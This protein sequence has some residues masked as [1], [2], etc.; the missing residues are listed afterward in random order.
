MFERIGHGAAGRFANGSAVLADQ[1]H[2]RIAVGVM[3]HA[4][5]KCVAA[6]DAMDET[7][8]AQEVERAVY[9]DRRQPA[10]MRQSL[11]DFVSAEWGSGAVRAWRIAL[12]HA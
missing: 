1:K 2:D 5:D 3:M 9:R 6:L 12:P 10:A 8:V 11:D 4:G 7:V